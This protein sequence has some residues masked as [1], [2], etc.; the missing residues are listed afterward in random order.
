MSFLADVVRDVGTEILASLVLMVLASTVAV[1][2]YRKLAMAKRLKG[3]WRSRWGD[4]SSKTLEYEES[5]EITRQIGY[6]VWGVAKWD[7]LPDEKWDLWGWIFDD[8]ILILFYIATSGKLADYGCYILERQ[9]RTDHFVGA[10]I[11]YGKYAYEERPGIFVHHHE[12]ARW[13][14]DA[15]KSK[16]TVRSK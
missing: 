10:S 3:H 1:S 16:E 4:W 8:K 9:V 15:Y 13:D 12:M 7:L 11:G 6:R 2:M 14:F 5:I